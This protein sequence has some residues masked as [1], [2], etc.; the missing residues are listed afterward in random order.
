MGTVC[1]GTGTR[2]LYGFGTGTVRRGT[3]TGGLHSVGTDGATHSGEQNNACWHGQSRSEM[4]GT[5]TGGAVCSGEEVHLRFTD[6]GVD[7][8]PPPEEKTWVVDHIYSL[9]CLMCWST[10]F[11][12]GS[13]PPPPSSAAYASSSKN[14]DWDR[15]S[16]RIP[17]KIAPPHG[18]W[19]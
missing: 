11:L 17:L 8:A 7:N 15:V 6:C 16:V 13:S 4:H 1:C 10:F 5:E 19:E 12:L 3:G 18:F 14:P 9:P 2:E